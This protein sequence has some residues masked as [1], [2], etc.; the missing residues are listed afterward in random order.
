MHRRLYFSAIVRPGEQ[1]S[2][3]PL[4]PSRGLP[5]ASRMNLE[6]RIFSASFLDIPFHRTSRLRI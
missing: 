5:S 4:E 6:S 2:D 1:P 3:K